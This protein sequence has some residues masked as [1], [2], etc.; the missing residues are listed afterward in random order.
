M[1]SSRRAS[2]RVPQSE[3]R[4]VRYFEKV[5]SNIRAGRMEDDSVVDISSESFRK[6][7]LDI[8]VGLHRPIVR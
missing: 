8:I 1:T 7:T 6:A 2:E 4:I 5:D 3:I